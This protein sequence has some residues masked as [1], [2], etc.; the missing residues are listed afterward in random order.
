MVSHDVI[1]FA[2]NQ[3][4]LS[5]VSPRFAPETVGSCSRNCQS[6]ELRLSS[7]YRKFYGHD[8]GKGL[9]WIVTWLKSSISIC[10]DLLWL[11][12][13]VDGSLNFRQL[14]DWA[15]QHTNLHNIT[16][17]VTLKLPRSITPGIR[18]PSSA[19]EASSLPGSTWANLVHRHTASNSAWK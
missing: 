15:V 1:K 9:S 8:M 10:F 11:S 5:W 18:S 16:Q 3:H 6:L 2:E 7:A 13:R 14:F 17:Y 12:H 4:S 19:L